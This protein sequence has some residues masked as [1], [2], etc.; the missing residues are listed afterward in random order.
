[1]SDIISVIAIIL[2][3]TCW[4]VVIVKVMV[5][6]Y[7]A[8]KTVSAEVVDKYKT[9]GFSG[10]SGALKRAH[11]IVVFSTGEKK[12]SFSVSEFSY[13]SYQMHDKGILEYKG[14]QIIS[15]Q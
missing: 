14:N 2:F 13:S 4:I 7:A 8:V 5:K 11:Y 3:W 15:F 12:R 1:M 10:Y 9:Y 6:R